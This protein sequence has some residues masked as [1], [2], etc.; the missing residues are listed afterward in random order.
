M[1]L[2]IE[3]RDLRKIY[4]MGEEEVH[5]LRGVSFKVVKQEFISIM[6]PSGSGKST[7]LHIL[8]C[9]DRPTSG[10]LL[11]EGQNI[12]KA[13]GNQLAEIRNRRIGF[14]FQNFNLL[15]K[16]TAL[17]NVEL[18]L[19]YAGV[20]GR[21]RRERAEVVLERVGLADR[22]AHRPPELSGGQR[23]RV[24]IARAMVTEPTFI[25]AD[26]PTGALDSKTSAQIMELFAELNAEGNTILIITHDP[27]VA[28]QTKRIIHLLDGQ[29]IK[30]TAGD[31]VSA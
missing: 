3:A 19:I 24:A 28:K 23:Q 15:P 12:Q 2:V 6:G 11:I 22:M 18:P 9:L 25:L 30:D 10:E 29:I 7:L 13:T 5:A 31:G 20:R 14:V 1:S 21:E 4:H 17:E 27:T 26:E 8:G 16:A